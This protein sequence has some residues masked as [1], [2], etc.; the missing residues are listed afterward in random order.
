MPVIE[1]IHTA[2]LNAVSVGKLDMSHWHT[3]ETT[4]CRAGWVVHIA[5]EKG[6]E[7]ERETST[8][9]AASQIYKKSSEIKVSPVS[10]YVGDKE[11][12]KDIKDCAEKEAL[13]N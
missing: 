11:A 6:K 3:C 12:M 13:E 8:A 10:F 4:H 5:G 1:N 9:F 7:L 2:V